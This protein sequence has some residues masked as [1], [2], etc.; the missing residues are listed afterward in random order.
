MR[1]RKAVSQG[2]LHATLW[3][4]LQVGKPAQRTASFMPGNPST[5]VA[6]HERLA[7]LEGLSSDIAVQTF[8]W[9][10]SSDFCQQD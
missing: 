8:I 3:Q 2:D 10:L 6:A 9:N 7:H 1:R 5:A 4:L